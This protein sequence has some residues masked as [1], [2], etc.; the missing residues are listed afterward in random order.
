[1]RVASCGSVV[2]AFFLSGCTL[3]LPFHM[4]GPLPAPRWR[5]DPTLNAG[6]KVRVWVPA[7]EDY[8]RIASV[9]A[10]SGDTIVLDQWPSRSGAAQ[11]GPTAVRIS[12]PLGAV[13]RLEVS[14]GFHRHVQAGFA[15]GALAG[16]IAGY[17]ACG[18]TWGYVPECTHPEVFYIVAVPIALVGAAI[19][20]RWTEEWEDIPLDALRRLRVDLVPQPR[21]RVGLGASLAL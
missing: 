20:S 10:L 1:M 8:V 3:A 18:P 17:L 5:P 13:G 15:F 4:A 7:S 12:L 19:G 6:E 16:G 14:H 9:V 2:L 21:G 11:S